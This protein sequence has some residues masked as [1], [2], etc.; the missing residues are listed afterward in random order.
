MNCSLLETWGVVEDDVFFKKMA[1]LG[2]SVYCFLRRDGKLSIMFH[3]VRARGMLA[4]P[5]I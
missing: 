1:G 5:A 3:L 4:C 2:V